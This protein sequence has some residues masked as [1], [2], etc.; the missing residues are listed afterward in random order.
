MNN[1]ITYAG[2]KMHSDR[3]EPFIIL[4]PKGQ[5]SRLIKLSREDGFGSA[6]NL[7]RNLFD[8]YENNR[9]G[10]KSKLSKKKNAKTQ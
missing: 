10:L 5:K 9:E 6:A 1:Y 7:G 3:L 8:F 2:V 4:L